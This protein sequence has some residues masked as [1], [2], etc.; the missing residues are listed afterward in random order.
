[1]VVI[2]HR[3]EMELMEERELGLKHVEF[4]MKEGHPDEDVSHE[5]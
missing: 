1:M 4:E 3:E 5:V 2:V